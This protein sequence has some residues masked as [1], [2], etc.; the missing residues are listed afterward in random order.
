MGFPGGSEWIIIL[1]VLLLFFGAKKLP[2][3]ARSMGQA[4]K[5]F[6]SGLKE[7]HKEQRV[8]GPCP[9]CDTDV[10]A[11]AKFCPECGKSAADIVAERT[12]RAAEKPA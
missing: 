3:L 6:R 9:F 1:A 2:E 5:E 12:R 10:P 4:S 7:G 8:E 11:E